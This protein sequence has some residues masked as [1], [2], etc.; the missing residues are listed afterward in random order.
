MNFLPDTDVIIN[1]LKG[2]EPAKSFLKKMIISDD[3]YISPISIAEYQAKSSQEEKS[4]L[5][6]FLTLGKTVSIDSEVGFIAGDYRKQFSKKTKK[7]YLMD[8]FIAATCKAHKLTLI[9]NN[10]K[11]YPMG[12]I[13]IL[14]PGR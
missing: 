11:D 8:C 9:T 10:L 7:V 2:L 1:Y 12:D 3:L 13:K 5:E 6:E 14:Q 4:L